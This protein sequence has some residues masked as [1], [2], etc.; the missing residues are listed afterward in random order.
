MILVRNAF[1]EALCISRHPKHGHLIDIAYNNCFL[2]ETRSVLDSA[3]APPLLY[4]LL[5]YNDK[6]SIFSTY[7]SM[8]T[9][10]NNGVKVYRDVA[11]VGQIADLVL[12]FPT[13]WES[14]SFVQVPPER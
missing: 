13:I 4:Q 2:T 3:T 5:G 8:E 10:L 1:N 9:V 7:P 6:F 11:A 14:Q 12:E